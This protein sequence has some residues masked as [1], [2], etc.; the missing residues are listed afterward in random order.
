MTDLLNKLLYNT[1]L[2]YKSH[3][4][5]V[6]SKNLYFWHEGLWVDNIAVIKYNKLC[7]TSNHFITLALS[8]SKT[9]SLKKV[10]YQEIGTKNIKA[11]RIFS[12]IL[13]NYEDIILNRINK[14]E[15][16]IDDIV[17]YLHNCFTVANA[18]HD[19]LYILDTLQHYL[20][21]DNIKFIIFSEVSDNY[22]NNKIINLLVDESRLIKIKSGTIYNISNRIIHNELA[23]YQ[24]CNYMKIIH[25]IRLG[26]IEYIEKKYDTNEIENM[27]N[28]NVIIIKN[29]KNSLVTRYYNC[30]NANILFNELEK[31]GWYICNPNNDDFYEMTFKLMF[32]NKTVIG[33]HL[34][35]ISCANQIFLNLSKDI[36]CFEVNNL[37]RMEKRYKVKKKFTN[38]FYASHI[39]FYILSPINITINHVETFKKLV[40]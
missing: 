27:K 32:A 35:G 6:S 24:V 16:N 1:P 22:N 20:N 2:K 4:K 8:L 18:G 23:K 40:N 13:K 31:D 15:E 25:R 30:F 12:R 14:P 37:D 9:N 5:I 3:G 19:L 17:V 38:A 34:S 36:Y 26:I 10:T 7:T 33:P 11:H 29:N 39:K 21:N 28:K